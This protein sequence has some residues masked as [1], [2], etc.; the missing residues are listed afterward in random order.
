MANTAAIRKRVDRWQ[1]L[2]P[3]RQQGILP[4]AGKPLLTG[5]PYPAPRAS[6]ALGGMSWMITLVAVLAGSSLAV[7]RSAPAS[8]RDFLMRRIGDLA[9]VWPVA[10]FNTPNG[11]V[12]HVAHSWS[13]FYQHKKLSSPACRRGRK[14]I[15]C[16]ND[17]PFSR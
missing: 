3:V 14:L 12:P 1:I 7:P 11:L 15:H 4:A 17:L 5:L 13:F 16:G 6:A 9:D 8:S 10:A 2:N